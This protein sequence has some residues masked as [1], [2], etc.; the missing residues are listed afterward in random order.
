MAIDLK[1]DTATHDVVIENGDLLL[2]DEAEEVA[3]SAKIRVLTWQGEWILDYTRG[4]PWLDKI[5][6]V[7]VSDTEKK[8]IIRKEIINT[9]GFKDL[10]N[11]DLG[12]DYS[13]HGAQI[14]FSGTTIY[15][16]I[17]VEIIT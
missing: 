3:Q 7:S 15:G 4:V 14:T 5:F 2:I 9:L 17:I 8:Q 6:S 12:M 1:L 11:I 13:A 10:I 16:D